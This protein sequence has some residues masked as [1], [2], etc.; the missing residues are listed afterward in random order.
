[1]DSE[2]EFLGHS[3]DGRTQ[4]LKEHLVNTAERC[5]SFAVEPLKDY[6]Y[7]MGLYH[8]LGK[9][10]PTF[11]RRIRGAEERIDHAVCGAVADKTPYIDESTATMMNVAIMCH[12]TGLRDIGT[13]F[14]TDPRTYFGRRNTPTEDFMAYKEELGGLFRSIDPKAFM[15]FLAQDC[16]TKGQ[17]VDKVAFFERYLFSCLTDADTL[18]TKTFAEH[19]VVRGLRSDFTGCLQ[20]IDAKLQSF[21]PTTPLQKARAKVQAQVFEKVNVDGDIYL[22]NMP[23]GSGKTLC[24]VKFA[25]ERALKK[26]KKRII[27]IIPFNSIIDQT[28]QEFEA[29]FDGVGQILQHQSTYDYTKHGASLSEDDIQL[30][31]DATE[32]WDSDFIITTVVQFFESLYGNKRSKLRKLHNMQDAVLVFDEVHMLPMAFLGPCLQGI[33]YL[34]KYLHSEAIFLTATM[35]DFETLLRETVKIETDIVNLIEDTSDFEAFRKCTYSFEDNLSDEALLARMTAPSQLV[36]VNKKMTARRLYQMAQGE[37]YHLST[38]MTSRDRKTTIARIRER[39]AQLERDYPGLEYVPETRRITVVSTS[40][41]EAGVDLDFQSVYRELSG[42][43]SILQAGGRCNREGKYGTRK[44]VVFKRAEEVYS[45]QRMRLAEQ[46][47]TER[48]DIQDLNVI[49]EYYKLYHRDQQESIEAHFMHQTTT[50]LMSIPY[51]TYAE[52][53]KLIDDQNVSIV[54]PQDPKTAAHIDALRA[55]QNVSARQFQNATVTV[56]QKDFQTLCEQGVVEILDSGVIVLTHLGYYDETLGI[57][58]ES[59]VE[60]YIF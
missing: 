34:T 12:H 38:Y 32:N 18:D 3:Y 16:T 20:R 60:D 35:P 39:L 30:V 59:H 17:L 57:L 47:M 49:R 46:V 15:A 51:E 40:L 41:I 52:K 13:K 14:D 11:Q 6:A 4:P 45:K 55:G 26:K 50:A 5:E 58:F 9:Y 36:V 22:M 37:T 42:L 10:Q 29:L 7:A 28:S 43:D 44:V 2:Q 53:F 56:S 21:Q 25:L 19:R 24:S 54:V 33:A 31:K 48:S 23:T 27:Y 1:M 8:D